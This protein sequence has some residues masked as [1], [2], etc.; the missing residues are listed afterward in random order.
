MICFIA[1]FVFAILAIFSARY[2]PFARDAFDCVFRR[3]TLR[4]CTTGFDKK[5]K[6]RISTKLVQKNPKFG[7]LVNKHFE[8]ISWALTIAMVLSFVYSAIGIYNWWAFGN[9]NGPNSSAACIFNDLTGKK[10]PIGCECNLAGCTQQDIG[11]CKSDCNCLSKICPQAS[12]M[13]AQ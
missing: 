2:R 7:R 10:E 9:C 1:L 3:M 13:Q 5:M 11:Y 12:I 6:M 8:L 4:K